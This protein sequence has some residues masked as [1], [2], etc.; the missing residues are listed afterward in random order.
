M[1]AIVNL[2]D[3]DSKHPYSQLSGHVYYKMSAYTWTRNGIA[4]YRAQCQTEL[5]RSELW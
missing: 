4:D 2:T 5:L 1:N 3:Y